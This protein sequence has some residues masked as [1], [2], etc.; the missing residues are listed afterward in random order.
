MSFAELDCDACVSEF[1]SNGGCNCMRAGEECDVS[2]LIPDGCYPC[3]E[4]ASAY[5]DSLPSDGK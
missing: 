5:C 4:E 3:G 1:A 2:A